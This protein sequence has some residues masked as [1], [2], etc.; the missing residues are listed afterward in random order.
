MRVAKAD[1]VRWKEDMQR[2]NLHTSTVR[3]DLSECSAV[4][5]WAI[6]NGKL[7][8][9]TINPFDGISP[10]K[11]MKCRREARGFTQ[12]EAVTI[13]TAA[14][15]QRGVLRWAPWVCS[16]TGARLNEICQSV[17]EDVTAVDGVPVL[18]IHDEGEG[19]SVKNAD[20]RRTVP[21]HP[22]L[23]TEGF[24]SYVASLPHGSPLF[25]DVRPDAVFGLRSTEAGRKVGKWLRE[26]LGLDDPRISPNHSWRYFYVDAC[27]RVFHAS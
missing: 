20:S 9:G 18:R 26:M 15:E 3:N 1:A 2:R 14:R 27:R 11:A 25:P 23:V 24:V 8:E 4:W 10:P 7:P 19:R 13:L 5:K 16:L 22:A 21:L 6:R 12:A 17:K